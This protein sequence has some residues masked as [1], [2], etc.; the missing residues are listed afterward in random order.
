MLRKPMA[1]EA[2]EITRRGEEIFAK[3]V[4]QKIEGEDPENCVVIDVDSGDFEVDADDVLASD[5][6]LER[7]PNARAYLRRVGSKFLYHFGGSSR[8]R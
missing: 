8:R 4:R 6:L 5:R 3:S 7:R 1:N 2:D